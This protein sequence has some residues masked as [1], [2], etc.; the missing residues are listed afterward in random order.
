MDKPAAR[1]DI[2]YLNF[3]NKTISY[4]CLLKRYVVPLP[5]IDMSLWW[6]DLQ[7]EHLWSTCEGTDSVSSGSDQA[8]YTSNGDRSR[9]MTRGKYS[10]YFYD[11]SDATSQSG[12]IKRRSR[13]Q[14]RGKRDVELPCRLEGARA[15][16]QS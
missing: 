14:S 15:F 7:E 1:D 3:F 16:R 10:F 9:H 5:L 13:A 8:H 6:I 12:G 2:V 4:D 11:H